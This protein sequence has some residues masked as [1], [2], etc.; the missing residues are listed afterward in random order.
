M[1]LLGEQPI[2][3][4]EGAGKVR[5]QRRVAGEL[6]PDVACHPAE[7]GLEPLDLALGAVV[8]AGMQIGAGL[9]Q[10]PLAE[11]GVALAQ[12]EAVLGGETDQDLAA[13]VVEPGIGG[14]GHRLRLHRR[15]EGHALELLRRDNA[16]IET[17]RDR[18]LE[19]N[20]HAAGADPLAPARHRGAVDRQF[21]LEVIKAAEMLVVRVL[22]PARAHHLVR[23]VEDV[24]QEVQPDHQPRRQPR[25]SDLRVERPER[26]LEHPPVDH[27]RQP[28]HL[29][30]RI[31]DV[32]QAGAEQVIGRCREGLFGT[33]RRLRTRWLA[34][35]NQGRFHGA[36]LSA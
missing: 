6:A 13:T 34:G 36:S 7:K 35:V 22:H 31:D 15:V 18:R 17:R 32:A 16:A 8:L 14:M 19:Q 25:P 24:L 5:C 30:A 4:G 1:P 33:H 26:R 20:L 10:H 21:M 28:D 9:A 29:V 23:Q 2:D 27:L 12:H 11:A 3:Q